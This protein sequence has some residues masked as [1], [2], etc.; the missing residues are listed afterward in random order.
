MQSFTFQ[1]FG[2]VSVLGENLDFLV[3]W[4]LTFKEILITKPQNQALLNQ[5]LEILPE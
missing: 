3:P 2:V 4:D 1:I 5:S